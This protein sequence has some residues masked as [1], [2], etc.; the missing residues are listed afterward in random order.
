MNSLIHIKDLRSDENWAFIEKQD[1][2]SDEELWFHI[3][4]TNLFS[5]LLLCFISCNNLYKMTL[6]LVS[7]T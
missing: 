5:E 3:P 4:G 2:R 1:L 6:V 7:I